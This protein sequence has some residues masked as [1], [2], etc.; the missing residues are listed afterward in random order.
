MF[1]FI[2]RIVLYLKRAASKKCAPQ[3]VSL[4]PVLE[5]EEILIENFNN[6]FNTIFNHRNQA[7]EEWMNFVNHL[8]RHVEKDDIRT[9]LKWDIIKKTMFVGNQ[10]YLRSEFD[11]LTQSD[12]WES[13]WSKA[14]VESPI[15]QPLSSNLYPISS[16]NLIHHAYHLVQFEEQKNKSIEKMDYV[17]EFGGGYGSMCRLFYNLGFSGT[18]LIFD[19]PP[20][21]ALQKFYLKSLFLP[22]QNFSPQDHMKNRGIFCVSDLGLL[23]EILHK[24]SDVIKLNALFLATWSLSEVPLELRNNIAPLISEFNNFLIGYQENAFGIDNRAY[25]DDFKK[26]ISS[27]SWDNW[28]IEHLRGNWY[29]MGCSLPN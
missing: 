23:K 14:V 24:S 19:L 12:A 3:G 16:G 25:F 9:F 18:Y 28:E 2:N 7:T 8:Q 1:E 20:F 29:L 5:H 13:K 22:V 11:H 6:E 27:M 15:G 17:F 21:T 26:N 4:P 10:P